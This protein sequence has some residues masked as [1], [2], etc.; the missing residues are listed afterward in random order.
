MATFNFNN[1]IKNQ[2]QYQESILILKNNFKSQVLWKKF[3]FESCNHLNATPMKFVVFFLMFLFNLSAQNFDKD[4]ELLKVK[5][6]K[7]LDKGQNMLGCSQKYYTQMDSLLNVVYKNRRSKLS[8]TEQLD[9]KNK[10]L[11]WLKKRDVQFVK[12]DNQDTGLGNGL[13]DLMVKTQEKANFVA[14]RILFLIDT[15]QEVKVGDYQTQL[16]NFV[17]KGYEILDSIKGNLNNDAFDDYIL[18]LK[19]KNEEETSDYANDKPKKRPLFILVGNSEHK[20]EL[21]ARND[22]AVLCIDC[23]G[24]IHGDSYV[25]VTI[26]NSYFSVE[27][28]TVGGNDKWSKIITFKYDKVLDKWVLH[29]DGMEFFGWNPNE[30]TNEEAIVKTGGKILTK[31]DFGLVLFEKYDIYKD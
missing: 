22:N 14:D 10:Q 28:Y 19:V 16:L 15:A 27:H 13:D 29:Q 5:N 2:F 21:K 26:K 9:L 20:L 1:N 31:K 18:I 4:L 6:Q 23:S 11:L 7:C 24:A 17:L 25:G 3:N 12:I 30:G 8:P